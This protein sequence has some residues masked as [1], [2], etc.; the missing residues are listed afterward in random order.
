VFTLVLFAAL[1]FPPQQGSTPQE[2]QAPIAPEKVL[3]WQLEGLTQEEIREEVNRRGLTECAEQPLLNALSAARADVETVRTVQHAKAPCTVWKLDL[4][5]PRPT[6]YLYEVAGAI[7][8]SDWGRALGTMQTEISKQPRDADVHMIYAHLLS[9]AGDWIAACAEV[10]EAVALARQWPYPHA[11]RST[12][13]YHS[14]LT[15]CAVREAV[16]FVKLRPQDAFAYIVLAHA[17]ELQGHDDEALLAYSEAKR[18]HA[19][20]AE[21][22]DG[23]GRIYARAGEFE[24]AVAAFQEAIR[25]DGREVEYY[26]ELAQL[27]QAEGDTELAIEKWKQ[28][29]ALD[30][31][32][33]E[34][35]FAL[36]NAYLVAKHYLEAIREYKELLEN[37]PEMESVR[38]QLAKALRAE[39]REE[40]AERLYEE[41]LAQPDIEKSH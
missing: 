38:A 16:V 4:R 17:K 18:L 32:R 39:G 24:K 11:Q 5:L 12:I 36:G 14:A 30:P 9:L 15:E 29:K 26:A 3:A 6:D 25:L 41:P 13:C 20:Y 40:E 28:A 27:Y 33:P 8:W 7:Q 19:S 2:L 31:N 37:A 35:S 10:S 1:A 22:P 34:I 23:F 21:I